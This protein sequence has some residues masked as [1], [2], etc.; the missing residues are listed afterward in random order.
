MEP[1]G[2][3][4]TKPG[5]VFQVSVVSDQAPVTGYRT[6]VTLSLAVRRAYTR[7]FALETL[8]SVPRSNLR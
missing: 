1:R 6:A 7:S 2:L 5:R 8:A 4:L 3:V